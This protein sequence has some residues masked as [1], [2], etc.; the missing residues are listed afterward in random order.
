MTEYQKNYSSMQPLMFDQSSRTNKAKKIIAVLQ[1]FLDDSKNKTVLDIGCSTGI[2]TNYFSSYFQ[3]IDG[4]DLDEHAINIAI[5]NNKKDNVKFYASPIEEFYSDKTYDIIICSHIYEHVPDAEILFESIYKLLKPGGICYLAAGN[6]YQIFEN[7]YKLYFLSYFPKFISNKYLKLMGKG[8]YYYETH[9]SLFKLNKLIDKFK[10]YDY[11]IKILNDPK[12]YKFE[13]T[14]K[15]NSFKQY[16]IKFL[17]KPFYF[18]IPT[19]IWILS[20]EV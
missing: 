15:A 17:M 4:L 16:L 14:I 2:I 10:K 9:L 5:K 6:R 12:K 7:H 13:E 18:F 20:K 11:T 3:H 8:D 19:Y 1:D